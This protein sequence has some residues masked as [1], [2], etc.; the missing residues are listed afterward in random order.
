MGDTAVRKATY[1]DLVKVPDHLVAEII[2]GALET[3]PRPAPR[4]ALAEFRLGQRIGSPFGDEEGGGPGGW[5]ILIEPELHLGDQIVVPDLAGWRRERLPDLPQTAWF[6]LAPDWVCEIL[7]PATARLDRV[8]KSRIYAKAGVGHY[9]MVDPDAKTLEAFALQ[10][11]QWVV[12]ATLGAGEEV[13]VDPF[14]A[15]PF[16]I[17]DL[18]TY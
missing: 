15:A 10:D 14:A 9:W 8:A 2:D 18:W 5:L 17:D 1:A 11:G 6:E 3:H 16:A 13:A 12:I 7:S 4:H